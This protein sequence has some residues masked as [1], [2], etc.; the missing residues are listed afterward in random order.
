MVFLVLESTGN[1]VVYR[2]V[3][4]WEKS[5]TAYSDKAKV[6]REMASVEAWRE[7]DC[8]DY[9]VRRGVLIKTGGLGKQKNIMV[10]RSTNVQ[11]TP[12]LGA[13]SICW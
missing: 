2:R 7:T 11:V 8:D 10:H 12:S 6:K 4:L 3:G 5:R 1:D 9:L 13:L